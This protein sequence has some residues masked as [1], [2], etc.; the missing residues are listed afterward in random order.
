VA[1]DGR[2]ATVRIADRGLGMSE[3]K[4]A[5]ANQ[6]LGRTGSGEPAAVASATAQ[7]GLW[8]VGRLAAR[9]GIAVRLRALNT[10]I[11]AE[12]SIPAPL[13]A[14]A[15]ARPYA[16]LARSVLRSSMTHLLGR[17]AQG[18]S[19]ERRNAGPDAGHARSGPEAG[20]NGGGTDADRVGGGPGAPARDPDPPAATAVPNRPP[21]AR[22][23]PDQADGTLPRRI[24]GGPRLGV[25]PAAAPAVAGPGGNGASDD[26]PPDDRD[27][28][29]MGS[30][31][32]PRQPAEST[33][34]STVES[35][36]FSYLAPPRPVEPDPDVA[37]LDGWT[38]PIRLPAQPSRRAAAEGHRPRRERPHTNA[39]PAAASSPVRP[40][41]RPATV[42]TTPARPNAAMVPAPADGGTSRAGLPV[43]V[44]MAQLPRN[45]LAGP[46]AAA[47]G[48]TP[49]ESDPA[50]VSAALNRFYRARHRASSDD[51]LG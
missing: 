24:A 8:V 45:P 19:D 43:R 10:G 40:V 41:A 50:E 7:M 16:D 20:R 23:V 25:V 38:R 21:A 30:M 49:D 51:T 29:P 34:E 26:V 27:T 1:P 33:A 15:P 13:L 22:P 4:L 2:S 17:E 37:N 11:Q 46:P 48:E 35:A 32:L 39:A 28:P 6:R 47:A 3:K 12:I 42:A 18:V 14:P 31:P 9:H 5:E 44:P 36:A